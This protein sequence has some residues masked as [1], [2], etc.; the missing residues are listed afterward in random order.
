MQ[1]KFAPAERASR[2][3]LLRQATLFQDNEVL[4]RFLGKIHAVF[5]VLNQQRQIVY[6]NS[7]ALEFAELEAVDDAL[8]KRPGELLNC[9]HA[10][11][12]EGG[13]GTSAACRYCGAANAILT[14]LRGNESVRDCHIPVSVAG[15]ESA[16]D[17][18][19]WTSPL[20]LAGE[21]FSMFTIYDIGDEKRRNALERVFFHDVLNTAG[22]LQGTLDL[23]RRYG[24]KI[25]FAEQLAR[26]D[27]I[28]RALIDEIRGQQMLAAAEEGSLLP[29][30]EAVKSITLLQQV[31]RVFTDHEVARGKT[32]AVASDAQA[33]RL[34]TDPAILRRIVGNMVKNALEAIAEGEC[35][36]LGCTLLSP[37]DG[38]AVANSPRARF[39]IHN[40]GVIPRAARLQIFTRSFTTK[41]KG[42]GLG[43]Y[44]MWL[45]GR[46]LGGEVGFTTSE[47][48]GTCFHVDVPVARPAAPG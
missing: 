47:A 11:E 21:T 22:G 41:G 5:L 31:T 38:S 35:V 7:G 29:H 36:T 37:G 14:S 16:L 23:L 12:E 6:M 42:R 33:F 39:T 28:L 19:V 2:A 9:A 46:A 45:L 32:I 15:G 8:G 20:I 40:P 44:S 18:R 13:C 24:D 17:L 25:D 4:H 43:T 27:T 26:A 34:E 30:Y 1:T 10:T 48:E 3:T